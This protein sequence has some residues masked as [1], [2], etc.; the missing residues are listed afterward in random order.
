MSVS[1]KEHEIRRIIR[2]ELQKASL[3]EG[4][5]HEGITS[6]VSAAS[7]LLKA[8]DAFRNDATPSA[9]NAVSP[10]IDDVVSRLEDMVSNPGGYVERQPNQRVVSL[11]AQKSE[12]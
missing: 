12:D 9:V 1:F 5:D 11:R 6:V 7:K 10:T 8:I 4:V 2:E 3:A